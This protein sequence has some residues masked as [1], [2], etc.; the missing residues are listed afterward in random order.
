M[1]KYKV[2]KCFW[3][4]FLWILVFFS[5]NIYA[6]EVTTRIFP[7]SVV[8]GERSRINIAATAGPNDSVLR[9]NYCFLNPRV[10][11]IPNRVDPDIKNK[12]DCDE[13]NG[14]WEVCD[15]DHKHWKLQIMM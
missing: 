13:F 11:A 4:L 2:G 8:E 14:S 6:L 3:Y 9:G 7:A 12:S 1:I 5:P 15:S 10:N